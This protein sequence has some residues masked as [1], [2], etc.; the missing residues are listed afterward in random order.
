[1]MQVQNCWT[2]TT[3][4]PKCFQATH[5]G[6]WARRRRVNHLKFR[7]LALLESCLKGQSREN[8]FNLFVFVGLEN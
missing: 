5:A 1:M 2:I 8:I 3:L 6:Q 4:R 7:Q